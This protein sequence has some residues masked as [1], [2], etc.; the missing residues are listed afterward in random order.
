MGEPVYPKTG[1]R[2]QRFPVRSCDTFPWQPELVDAAISAAI[3]AGV[4]C[5]YQATALV[6]N[7]VYTV[8]PA[9]EPVSWPTVRGDCPAMKALEERTWYRANYLIADVVDQEADAA[10][11]EAGGR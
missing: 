8:T 7:D 5:P 1:A 3:E 2:V 9:G 4:R 10:W 6:L 11:A